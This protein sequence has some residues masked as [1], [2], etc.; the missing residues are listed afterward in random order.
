MVCPGSSAF[1]SGISSSAQR[2]YSWFTNHSDRQADITVDFSRIRSH[3]LRGIRSDDRFLIRENGFSITRYGVLGRGGVVSVDFSE[4]SKSIN[5]TVDADPLGVSDFFERILNYLICWNLSVKGQIMVHGSAVEDKDG[6]AIT[7]CGGGGS[8]KTSVAVALANRGHRFLSDNYHVLSSDGLVSPFRTPLNVFGFN[9]GILRMHDG[10]HIPRA[11]K[12]ELA[13]KSVMGRVGLSL[14]TKVQP[15]A[16]GMLMHSGDAIPIGRCYAVHRCI[17][18]SVEG[19]SPTVFAGILHS[20]FE[21]DFPLMSQV[22]REMM[23]HFPGGR[24]GGF[25]DRYLTV[26]NRALRASRCYLM[27]SSSVSQTLTMLEQQGGESYER[28]PSS[29]NHPGGLT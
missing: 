17:T 27:R 8:G 3:S 26:G 22:V 15:D 4:D 9:S 1:P 23:Y 29:T 18:D 14:V 6:Q 25:G 10:N 7:I 24:F 20:D 16:L 19:V 5:V 21:A 2:E 11:K 28:N 12:A 13:V